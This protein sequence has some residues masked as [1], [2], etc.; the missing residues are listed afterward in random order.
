MNDD[1][2]DL[3]YGDARNRRASVSYAQIEAAARQLMSTGDYP[4]VAAVRNV[5]KRGST[6]TIAEAMQRFWKDQAALNAGN[7]NALTRL[8]PDFA[9]AA[10]ELWEQAL[11]LAQASASAGDNAARERLK[12][13]A[14]ENEVRAHSLTLREREWETAA[15]ER[16]RALAD[17][18]EHLLLL[19]TSLS[20]EQATVQA[21]DAR[22]AD[23]EAQIGQFRQQIAG[24][25]AGA[26]A[27][28]RAPPR[29]A[30]LKPPKA[31]SQEQ[32]KVRRTKQLV[33][34]RKSTQKPRA[35]SRRPVPTR[36]AS[37][38]KR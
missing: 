38:K 3:P 15:R 11:E 8:P 10:T 1:P 35:A 25:L 20:R 34:K 12:E 13:I 16:E 26:I 21:R 28:Q 33:A 32:P 19:S 36:R 31:R 24:L 37:R 30:A 14:A 23:L 17:A 4:S 27:R 29:R 7:P 5:L 9:R 6:T 22:I 18:R 2:R